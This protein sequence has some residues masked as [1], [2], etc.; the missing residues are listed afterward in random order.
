MNKLIELC[1]AKDGG[2]VVFENIKDIETK[3][4]KRLIELGFVKGTK[5]NV[6]KKTKEL[7]L[8]GIRGFSISLDYKL[9]E[10]IFVWEATN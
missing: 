9:C 7:I 4:H 8:V 10:K 1:F 2:I 6:I 5:I 3:M